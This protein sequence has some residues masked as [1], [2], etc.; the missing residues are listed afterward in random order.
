MIFFEKT[1]DK[2]RQIARNWK[3]TGKNWRNTRAPDLTAYFQLSTNHPSCVSSSFLYRDTHFPTIKRYFSFKSL[4][5]GQYK[6]LELTHSSV[7]IWSLVKRHRVSWLGI[8]SVWSLVKRHR[9]SWFG[10]ESAQLL[11]ATTLPQ[12]PEQLLTTCIF[13]SHLELVRT[14]LYTPFMC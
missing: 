14:S 9:V 8:R 1:I 3:K 11:F 4:S 12:Q 6:C 13:I 10:I 7:L 5:L 2:L